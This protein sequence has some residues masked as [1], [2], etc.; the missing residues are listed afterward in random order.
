[1]KKIAIVGLSPSTRNQIPSDFDIYALPWD[2]E[3]ASRASKLFEMHDRNLLSL[4]GSLREPDY[5]DRLAEYTQPIYMQKHWADIPTSIAFPLAELKK[6]IFNNFHRKWSGQVDFYNSS[7]AYMIALAIHEG[8]TTIGLY[9]IDVL[10]DSEYA[11]E[12]P[13]L[14]YLLGYA[15]GKGIE[16]ITP[17]GPTALGKFRGAGIKLGIMEPIYNN[18]YGY[19]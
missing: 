7:P 19:I 9:G 3:Y 11:Y 12:T 15:A 4:P 18:R 2:A 17:I 8:A 13:C 16:I 10:D 14:E 5:F 1:M 6:T